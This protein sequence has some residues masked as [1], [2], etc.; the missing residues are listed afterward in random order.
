MVVVQRTVSSE[1]LAYKLTKR[2]N[3]VCDLAGFAVRS[4]PLLF[5]FSS[6]GISVGN[7][8]IEISYICRRF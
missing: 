3:N 8:K 2:K 6:I 7:P 4:V 5:L 1:A